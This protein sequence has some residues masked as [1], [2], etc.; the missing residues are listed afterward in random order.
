M[1]VV[2][3]F[4]QGFRVFLIGVTVVEKPVVTTFQLSC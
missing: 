1:N 2:V 3:G 4:F